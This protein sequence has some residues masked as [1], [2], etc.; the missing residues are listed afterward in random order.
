MAS[1][2]QA[3]QKWVSTLAS[4]VYKG[5]QMKAD[6]QTNKF[7]SS[8]MHELGTCIDRLQ[9][10]HKAMQDLLLAGNTDMDQFKQVMAAGEKDKVRTATWL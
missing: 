6:L 9:K 8:L 5:Q 7:G 3:A 1:A 10:H 4:D 2:S